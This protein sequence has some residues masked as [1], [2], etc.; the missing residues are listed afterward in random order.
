MQDICDK[1]KVNAFKTIFTAAKRE[2]CGSR[3]RSNNEVIRDH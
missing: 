3:R 2:K 1:R